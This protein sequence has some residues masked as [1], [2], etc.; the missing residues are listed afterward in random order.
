MW[1]SLCRAGTGL[2]LL[3]CCVCWGRG[4]HAWIEPWI[5][6]GGQEAGDGQ[7]ATGELS[8]CDY[9]PLLIQALFLRRGQRE[10]NGLK[11]NISAALRFTL[12]SLLLPAW[13]CRPRTLLPSL[14]LSAVD[15]ELGDPACTRL[16]VRRRSL[17]DVLI[18]SSPGTSC[19]TRS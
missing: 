8:L 17:K 18:T 1:L 5:S 16:S 3:C 14:T 7:S 13:A 9:S 2:E 10:I 19:Y 6:W 4:W 11:E 15:T 12:T